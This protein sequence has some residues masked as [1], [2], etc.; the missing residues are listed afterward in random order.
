MNVVHFVTHNFH[1][2]PGGGEKWA[3]R[4]VTWLAQAGYRV[5]VYV[6]D[7][8]DDLDYKTVGREGGFEIRLLGRNRH[9]WE[10]PLVASQWSQASLANERARLD[11]LYLRNELVQCMTECPHS[12]HVVMS[13]YLVEQGFLAAQVA[14]ELDIPHVP[15][16]VG[17]DFSRGMRN[18]VERGRLDF[19]VRNARFVITMNAEQESSLR[20][21][22]GIDRITTI[23]VSAASFVD[24]RR[25]LEDTKLPLRLFS[26]TGFSFRKGTQVL[27]H[28]FLTLQAEG[29]PLSLH[30][31]GKTEDAQTSYWETLRSRAVAAGGS[32]I[33]FS[34]L[35]DDRGVGE[36]LGRCD[37]YCSATLGEGCSHARVSALCAGVPLVTTAC[38]EIPDVAAGTPHVRIC[39]P[40]DENAFVATLRAA[41]ADIVNGEIPVDLQRVQQWREHFAPERER[42]AYL[43]VLRGVLS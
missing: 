33:R 2:L 11:F 29:M 6:T 7:S 16:V 35:L 41:C 24:A 3:L 15:V 26:D 1:P 9:S 30:V 5:I 42:S 31:C 27:I 8:S 12:R 13:W 43:A 23:H 10:A 17:T 37:L 22:F 32:A 19:V 4:V 20:R 18:V 39:P 36:L 14:Q 40:A 38:G 28:A 25:A 21:S 34:D